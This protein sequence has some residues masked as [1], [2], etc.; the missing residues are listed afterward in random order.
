M[1]FRSGSLGASLSFADG[2]RR[3]MLP[4]PWRILPSYRL[5]LDGEKL[6]RP[7]ED[8]IFVLNDLARGKH[9][10]CFAQEG[11]ASSLEDYSHYRS[12]HRIPIEVEKHEMTVV[13]VDRSV[14]DTFRCYLEIRE[15]EFI[16]S[17]V[18]GELLKKKG[19][20]AGLL[21]HF[22][23]VLGGTIPFEDWEE[24][25][26]P[27]ATDPSGLVQDW[28]LAHRYLVDSSSIEGL[29][30]QDCLLVFKDDGFAVAN[31]SAKDRAG[32]SY[33]YRLVFEAS[34]TDEY[35]WMVS[36]MGVDPKNMSSAAFSP[37]R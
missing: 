26:L 29:H 10:L 16:L 11:K 1:L 21:E 4:E 14:E 19:S 2:E 18:F 35:P 27:N 25:F 13:F 15:H 30:L 9:D 5:V 36:S 12:L 22:E 3:G 24:I 32:E 28:L 34:R 33:F 23:G 37:L 20:I 7:N 31:L 17:E 6:I 8:G